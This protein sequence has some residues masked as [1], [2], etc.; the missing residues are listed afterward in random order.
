MNKPFDRELRPNR[1]QVIWWGFE[2]VWWQVGIR[3]WP[4]GWGLAIF[5]WFSI[6][7]GPLEIR[8]W[9][10]EKIQQRLIQELIEK[11]NEDEETA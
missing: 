8:V 6:L 1:V 10:S 11:Q 7:L 4:Q 3:Q 9:H 5:L 2:D